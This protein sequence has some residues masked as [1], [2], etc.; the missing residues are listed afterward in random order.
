VSGLALGGPEAG[1]YRLAKTS[2]TAEIGVISPSTVTPPPPRAPPLPTTPF[3]PVVPP[4]IVSAAPTAAPNAQ[5]LAVPTPELPQ[6]V[7]LSGCSG[8]DFIAVVPGE[9]GHVGAVVVESQGNKTVLHAAYAACSG[10]RPV[11]ASPQEVN[12]LFGGALAARPP[13]PIDFELYYRTGNLSLEP[14]A[15]AAFDKAFAEIGRR[16]TVDVVVTGFT[17][18]VGTPH[19]NDLLSM[20][21]AQAVTR[22][23]LAHG[24]KP[25]SITTVGRG[26]RSPQIPTAEQVAEEK[27][28]RVEITVR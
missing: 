24:L 2:A 23:L 20:A 7:R 1:D 9:D 8:A 16:T 26:E 11:I 15:L 19:G 10:S 6:M 14:D 4:Q 18:T 25:S 13:A 28:R 5:S 17:D 21:R 12:R 3:I 22:L 27:N